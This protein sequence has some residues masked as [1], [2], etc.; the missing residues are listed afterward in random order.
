MLFISQ[1]RFYMVKSQINLSASK[2]RGAKEKQT[3]NHG[4]RERP[5]L[6]GLPT[7]W[8]ASRSQRSADRTEGKGRRRLQRQTSQWSCYI[9][10]VFLKSVASPFDGITFSQNLL[11]RS[12]LSH[13]TLKIWFFPATAL[14][15]A[16]ISHHPIFQMSSAVEV[17]WILFQTFS[18]VLVA[19]SSMNTSNQQEILLFFTKY[20]WTRRYGAGQTLRLGDLGWLAASLSGGQLLSCQSSDGCRLI[21]QNRAAGV[22]LSGGQVQET[23]EGRFPFKHSTLVIFL[24]NQMMSCHTMNEIWFR[25]IDSFLCFRLQMMALLIRD[26]TGRWLR[27]Y[28]E[29]F[30]LELDE[31]NTKN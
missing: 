31:K 29:Q 15:T 7:C 22:R 9:P 18:G 28:H 1:K 23:S 8:E 21:C 25:I 3:K 30:S 24:Q 10:S 5:G 26:T 19:G 12:S 6:E 17:L 2:G 27:N 4:V 16:D 14:S 13:L 11:E 20:I